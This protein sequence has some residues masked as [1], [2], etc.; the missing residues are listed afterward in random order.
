MDTP[1]TNKQVVYIDA[2]SLKSDSLCDRRYLL[3]I[4]RGYT[5]G[6]R[7]ANYKAGYGTAFHAFLEAYYT[8]PPAK[9]SGEMPRLTRVGLD[10]YKK[11]VPHIDLTSVFEFRTEEHLEKSIKAYHERYQRGDS[12]VPLGNKIES[13]NIFLEPDTQHLLESKF[14]YPWYEDDKLIIYLT[15]TIDMVAD[16]HGQPIIL[17]HKSTGT[18]P[19][20]IN[21]FFTG[22]DMNIQTQLYVRMF[23]ILSGMDRYLPIMVNGIFIKKQT[24]KATDEGKFDGVQF[25]RSQL[26]EYTDEQMEQFEVWLVDTLNSIK[27]LIR[28]TDIS[29]LG[30]PNY[31]ACDAKFGRCVFYELCKNPPKFQAQVLKSHYY[32]EQYN[33][34]SFN[35]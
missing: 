4:V 22:F 5:R 28:N 27:A 18:R 7:A 15:G 32:V 21:D 9:R 3:H 19:D 8:V 10:A 24:K 17:D 29:N 30:Q 26:I 25:Q 33:P 13:P 1:T 6:L 14:M 16:H 12:I 31:A 34:M 20:K 2:S 23:R 11:Y 35:D